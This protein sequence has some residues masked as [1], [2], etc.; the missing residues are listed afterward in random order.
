MELDE[1]MKEHILIICIGYFM[2][3]L[4]GDPH[5]IWH[6]VK[7]IGK[8]IEWTEKLLW[9]LFALSEE[10]EVH[11]WKKRIAGS[12]LVVIVIGIVTGIIVGVFFLL[13]K[14]C[15]QLKLAAGCII[16]Y[17][18]L[19]MKSL[20]SE[21]MKVYHALMGQDTSTGWNLL[22]DGFLKK[23]INPKQES[24]TE[25]E[26]L[27]SARQNLS[28]IVGRD[29]EN[30]TKEEVVKAAIET[31]AENTSD[32]VIAPLF[33]MCIFGPIG[34]VIYKT[35]NTMDSMVGYQND[36]YQY[37]GTAAAKLDD[38]CNLIP[39][40][41]SALLMIIACNMTGL[42]GK[43]AW[44]IF[45]RDRYRHKSPNAGQTESVCA[46]AF[47]I[48]LAGP[49]YYFGERYE[50]RTV[51]DANRKVVPEDIV[52]VNTLMYTTANLMFLSF[53]VIAMM[54]YLKI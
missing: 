33:Y 28:M 23:D 36:R 47:H 8:L 30:L 34:G 51:G 38:L 40:R 46:G 45:K 26:K 6:P 42:D 44:R 12:L 4:L 9:K 10:K 17:Q 16:C 15:P 21:S 22:K 48:Q 53:V 18:M 43:N 31:V 25:A 50:K 49:A 27:L 1:Y 39:S 24:F 7:G 54:I 19:A 52:Q 37:F 20:K 32:G 5:Q 13:D 3:R 41:V 14:Y 2:D 35:V 29:T 11:K